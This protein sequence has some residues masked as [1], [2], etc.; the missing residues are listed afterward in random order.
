MPLDELLKDP[1]LAKKLDPDRRNREISAYFEKY[2]QELIDEPLDSNYVI[3]VGP[4]AGEF[5]SLARSKGHRILGIDAPSGDGGMGHNYLQAS[6]LFCEQRDVTVEYIGLSRWLHGNPLA[7]SVRFI[8]MRGSIEQ[9]FAQ[10][11]EG[12]PHHVH[13]DCRQL[14]WRR[15]RATQEAFESMMASYRRMLVSGGAVLIHANG[16]KSGDAWYSHA[17]EHAAQESNFELVISDGLL[18]KKWRKP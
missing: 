11:M 8:N 14:N 1:W 7:M 4:G 13:H 2:C 15:T 5:L 6:R 12:L 3:D 10:Y 9:C 17:I 16:S 18:L